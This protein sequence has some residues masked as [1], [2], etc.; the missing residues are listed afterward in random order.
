MSV[1]LISCF[2]FPFIGLWI[3]HLRYRSSQ[4]TIDSIPG[5]R[6]ESWIYGNIRELLLSKEYGE[7]E[8]RWLDTYGPVYSIKACFGESRLM[9]AAPLTAKYILNSPI[10]VHGAAHQKAANFSFGFGNVFLAQGEHHRYLRNIMNPGLSAKSVRAMLPALQQV[11]RK[12]ADQWDAHGFPGTT[13]DISRTLHDAI[14]DA[15]GD[16]ILE[17]PFNGLEGKSKLSEVQWTL[18]NTLSE[19]TE[20]T[21]LGDAIL[22]YVPETVFRLA[23]RLPLQTMRQIGEFTRVTDELSHELVQERRDGSGEDQ[24]GRGFI[25]PFLRGQTA[26]KGVPDEEIPVH[27]RTIL[28]AGV[29]TA[30]CALSFVLYKL[31]QMPDYQQALREE[32]QLATSMGGDCGPA[33]EKMSLLNAMINEVFRFYPPL[34]LSERM[35]ATDCVLPLSQPITTTTG[36][37]I[38]EIPVRKG[39]VLFV[40]TGAYH[41]LPSIWGA[42]AGEFKP[43]RWLEG[44]PCKGSA[45]GPHASLLSFSAGPGVCVGWRFAILEMQ[46]IVTELVRRFILSLPKDDSVRA[47]IAVTLQAMTEDGVRQLP[48]HIESV[49]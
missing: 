23:M 27:I 33:Y 40:S 43:S 45:L 17:H 25:D 46:V 44:V 3:L 26:H 38:T 34:P 14:I 1:A 24:H 47:R 18:M 15:I 42:D 31:A 28:I 11:G 13:V 22:P 4:T 30:G 48:I 5:P 49:V 2:L 6:S 9:V 29:D 19:V 36:V 32:I 41:R 35:A 37:Q 7:H 16:A 21:K 20:S 8:F 39:Q 12:L 10:F